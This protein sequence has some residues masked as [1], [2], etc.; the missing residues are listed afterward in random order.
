M[1]LETALV[2]SLLRSS[3]ELVRRS[4]ELRLRA[5]PPWKS[6][7][8]IDPSSD[9]RVPGGRRCVDE[10]WSVTERRD[11]LREGIDGRVSIAGG[12]VYMV[13]C[14]PVEVRDRIEGTVRMEGTGESDLVSGTVSEWSNASLETQTQMSR[15]Q[16][17]E[18]NECTNH[19][20]ATH[21]T[22][23]LAFSAPSLSS[24]SL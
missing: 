19:S 12:A 8:K 10:R 4:E 1:A 20:E 21:L 9:A 3:N 5:D 14:E 7:P 24:P 17:T 13:D 6:E 22:L 16:T 2:K 11:E 18:R 23:S 15:T